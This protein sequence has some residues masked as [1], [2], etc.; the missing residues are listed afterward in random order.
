MLCVSDS[1]LPSP[2]GVASTKKGSPELKKLGRNLARLRTAKGLTQEQLS[3]NARI[4]TRY[5]QDLEAGLYAPTIF[6]ADAL[7]KAL[8]CEWSDLLK[9]C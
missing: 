1:K 7:R 9:G 4:S 5:V 8:G 2:F 3:E 6:I